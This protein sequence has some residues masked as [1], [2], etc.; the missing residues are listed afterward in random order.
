MQVTDT[1]SVL[2]PEQLRDI[3]MCDEELMR[4][5]LDTLI[6]DTAEQIRL[7]S[8]AVRD[9]DAPGCARLAH[10]SRGAC[11]NVG[12][13]RAAAIFQQMES[14]ARAGA[15]QKCSASVQSLA[16]ELDL[17]RSAAEPY[18]RPELAPFTPAA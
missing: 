13:N 3:T 6:R 17:L 10:Y 14:D 9:G 15:I 2:D 16:R 12:A 7:L 1:I 5:I 4:E 11:A 8:A 18:L